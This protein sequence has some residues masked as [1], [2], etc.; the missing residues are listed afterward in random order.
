[1]LSL[2]MRTTY[3]GK[4]PAGHDS[5]TKLID[6][7]WTL[8]SVIHAVQYLHRRLGIVGGISSDPTSQR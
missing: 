4:I 3:P 7:E 8:A 5:I 1:M 6:L 2:A